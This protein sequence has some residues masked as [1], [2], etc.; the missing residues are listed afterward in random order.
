MVTLAPQRLTAGLRRAGFIPL[1]LLS[2]FTPLKMSIWFIG[3]SIGLIPYFNEVH[4]PAVIVEDLHELDGVAVRGGAIDLMA[5][6]DHQRQCTTNIARW[7]WRWR[8]DGAGHRVQQWIALGDPISPP[9]PLGDNIRYILT[10]PLPPSV[11]PGEWYYRG[12]AVDNC[13]FLPGLWAAAPRVS[14]DKPIVV[15]NPTP[16]APAPVS[17]PL[18]PVMLLPSK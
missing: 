8:D 11:E 7:L 6:I 2:Q 16:T 14:S 4:R 17:T 1:W 18:G 10:I 3:A 15:T 13:A 12:S 5:R 9:V